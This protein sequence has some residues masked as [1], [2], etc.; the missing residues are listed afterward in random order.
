MIEQLDQ[1]VAAP[2]QDDPLV[3]AFQLP[4]EVDAQQW[5][6][7]C[8]EVVEQEVRPGMLA[9]RDALHD[10]ALPIARSD[11]EPGLASL[12]GGLAAYDALLRYYTTTDHSASVA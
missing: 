3:M 5:R 7:R 2:A 12:E 8:A 4:A 1:M 9:Y 10:L 11:E 6:A